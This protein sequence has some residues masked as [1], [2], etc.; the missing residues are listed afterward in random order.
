VGEDY[1]TFF[2]W[3]VETC[4]MNKNGMKLRAAFER[5]QL[6]LCSVILSYPY[7]LPPRLLIRV[8]NEGNCFFENVL[9]IIE[10]LKDTQ[11]SPK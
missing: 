8:S 5:V 3:K 7:V 6:H 11:V 4:S 10:L 2:V 1:T 9:H